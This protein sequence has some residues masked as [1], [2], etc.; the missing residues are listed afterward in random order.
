MRVGEPQRIIKLGGVLNLRDVG[1]Y[2]T[3]DGRRTRW[4]TLLRS[5]CLDSLE[6]PGQAWLVAAGVR[7]VIDLRDSEEVAERP[8]VFA[9]STDLSYQRWPLWDGPPPGDLVP[10]LRRGYR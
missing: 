7:T 6:P 5:A 1:G 2:P 3:A 9:A 4:R 10:D 8:N